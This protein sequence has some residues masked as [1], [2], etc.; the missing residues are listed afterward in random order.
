MDLIIAP[1]MAEIMHVVA[2]KEKER[3]GLFGENGA[4]AQ[5]GFYSISASQSKLII[6]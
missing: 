3:P 2:S 1:I 6:S 4:Y 5:V